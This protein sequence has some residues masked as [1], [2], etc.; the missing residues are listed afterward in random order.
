MGLHGL[1]HYTIRP[2]DLEATKDF[3]EKILGLELG[4]RPPLT[5]PGYW[6]YCGD[7]PTV[8]LIGD[9]QGEEG[10]RNARSG[11]RAWWITSPFP[12]PGLP[13]CGRILISTR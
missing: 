4:Y 1:N 2:V 10:L 9:R 8:H 7:N 6:L 11:P 12:A 3:Y 13:P 5:F